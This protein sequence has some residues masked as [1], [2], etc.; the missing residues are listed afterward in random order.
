MCGIVGYIGQRP[1]EPLLLGQV[2]YRFQ[3]ED[4]LSVSRQ[5]HAHILSTTLTFFITDWASVRPFASWTTND[6]TIDQDYDILNSGVGL[7]LLAR[8]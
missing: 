5:D 8:F 7:N 2:F 6:S 4:Y 3:Y 1:A